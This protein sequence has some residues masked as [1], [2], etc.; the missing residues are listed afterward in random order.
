MKN[1]PWPASERRRSGHCVCCYFGGSRR[2]VGAGSKR[3]AYG[4]LR[5]HGCIVLASSEGG[6][7]LRGVDGRLE[8]GETSGD[9]SGDGA[10]CI[11][12]GAAA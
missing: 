5:V 8:I 9:H 11:F 3:T 4:S 10:L 12:V 1:G 7:L 2:T 6:W